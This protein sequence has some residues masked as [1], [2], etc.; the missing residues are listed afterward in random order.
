MRIHTGNTKI[1]KKMKDVHKAF[2]IWED[3][4]STDS[5]KNLKVAKDI[6]ILEGVQEIGCH[7]IFDIKIDI[8]FIQKA[9]FVADNHTTD[10]S[11]PNTYYRVVLMESV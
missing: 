9:K 1:P 7:M 10:P 11:S 4:N 5:N 8:K 6:K 2:T 3:G